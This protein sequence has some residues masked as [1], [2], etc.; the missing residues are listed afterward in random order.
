MEW[1]HLVRVVDSGEVD[2]SSSVVAGRGS[3]TRAAPNLERMTRRGISSP[4]RAGG[5]SSGSGRSGSLWP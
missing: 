1:G 5:S 4:G 2:H 3:I